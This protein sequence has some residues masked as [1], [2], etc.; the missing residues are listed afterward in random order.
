MSGQFLR[1]LGNGATEWASFA[2]PTDEQIEDAIDEW[3]EAHPEAVTTVQDGA[4]TAQKLNT[5]L[6]KAHQRSGT[7]MVYF[8]S[9]E[10]GE[11]SSAT[12][13]M[14]VEDKTVLFD[15][16]A[17]NCKTAIMNYYTEL[18][19]A[20]IF[21]NIDYIVISHYHHDHISNL[22]DILNAFPHDGC[23]AYIPLSPAQ[24]FPESDY[25]TNTLLG[26]RA[27]VISVLNTAGV[28]YTEVSETT[29]LTVKENFCEVELLN[30]T[31][32]AYSYYKN[33]L[34]FDTSSSSQLSN[35]YNNYSMVSLVK[36]GNVY[37]MFPGDIERGAQDYIISERTLPRLF[38]YA[39]HHHG[40]QNDDNIYYLDSIQ[41]EYGVIQTNH[42]RGL[43]SA[44]SS[45]AS[46]YAVTHLCSSGYSSYEFAIGKDG[47]YI[48][49]GSELNSSGW[50]YSYINLYVDSEYE[51]T[52]HDGTQEHPFSKIGEVLL[53]IKEKRNVHY[54]VRVMARE[55]EYDL[56]WLRDIGVAIDFYGVSTEDADKPKVK[57]AYIRNCNALSF[58]GFDFNGYRATQ[59]INAIVYARNSILNFSGCNFNGSQSGNDKSAYSVTA[60]LNHLSKVYMEG[61]TIENCRSGGRSYQYGEWITNGIEFTNVYMCYYQANH[62]ITIR[63]VDTVSDITYYIATNSATSSIPVSFSNQALAD[64]DSIKPLFLYNMDY[65]ISHNIQIRKDTYYLKGQY[66]RPVNGSIGDLNNAKFA[67]HYKY[68]NTASNRPSSSGGALYVLSYDDENYA[69][70]IAMINSVDDGSLFSRK[71]HASSGWSAWKKIAVEDI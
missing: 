64:F 35:M 9:L 53:F 50:Y 31:T 4:I 71:W 44:A 6:L 23:R 32:D 15:A 60:V 55:T 34:N 12:A 13:L 14:V 20:G 7:A 67:G 46:N 42:S 8:P 39:L 62:Q 48:V 40:I 65:A 11:Y 58:D 36:I 5:E 24:Y 30:S 16:S 43:E 22:E 2:E 18:Y 70:Q 66:L 33:N 27:S 69:H 29:I 54:Y 3:L 61:C 68:T 52:A 10:T 59:S 51:G 47:G 56:L 41:P 26:N 1:T 57:G 28:T 45:M 37:A 49:H 19:N 63:G 25:L 38:L 21:G 17:T